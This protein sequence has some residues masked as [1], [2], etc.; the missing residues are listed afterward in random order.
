[1]LDTR[2]VRN[3]RALR[4]RGDISTQDKNLPISRSPGWR[5][6]SAPSK[7]WRRHPCKRV[8]ELTR[9]NKGLDLARNRLGLLRTKPRHED[10]F[11]KPVKDS[12]LASKESGLRLKTNL[13]QKAL[14][15]LA[16]NKQEY[17]KENHQRRRAS[18]PDLSRLKEFNRAT[19]KEA[20]VELRSGRP[21]ERTHCVSSTNFRI[22][23]YNALKLTRHVEHETPPAE[24][25]GAPLG[26]VLPLGRETPGVRGDNSASVSME[27]PRMLNTSSSPLPRRS[28]AF[29]FPGRNRKDVGTAASCYVKRSKTIKIHGERSLGTRDRWSTDEKMDAEERTIRNHVDP[30]KIRALESSD[31][32]EES[33][34][35]LPFT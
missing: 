19:A 17:G 27:R 10:E 9:D 24:V 29:Q 31:S 35:S 15:D 13:K 21:F 7:S 28:V 5:H 16:A 12:A 33:D 8:S 25:Y 14:D 23:Y 3:S 26:D 11:Q 30:T 22:Q 20:L 32:E 4:E 6:S 2:D 18:V 1:M 34:D